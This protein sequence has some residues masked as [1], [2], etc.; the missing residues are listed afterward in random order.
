ENVTVTP[1][2]H[3]PLEKGGYILISIEDTGI[4]IQKKHLAKIFDPYF[5][6]KPKG[7]GLGLAGVFSIIKNHGGYVTAE[8]EPGSGTTFFIYL[9]AS[10]KE[11]AA[12]REA[13]GE[14]ITGTGR[15]L[16]MDDDETIRNVA[17][18]LLERLGY[19]VDSATDGREAI[20][21]YREAE[22]AG[23]P[24]DI[25][26][27]DLTVP[28]G[29]GGVETLEK[30]K[31]IDPGVKAIVSS[32]YSTESEFSEYEKFGF[33]DA[34]AKPYRMSDL[35]MVLHRTQIHTGDNTDPHR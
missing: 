8:S 20:T 14:V 33:R 19:E 6:T 29:M 25:V 12:R 2:D 23:T 17:T 18:R 16:L 30:L 34:I 4:G 1:E 15:I 28:G 26:I 22:K 5:T 35:S 27:L 10:D 11:I 3:L 7:S 31:E 9:P 13:G 21:K 24:F 32:G